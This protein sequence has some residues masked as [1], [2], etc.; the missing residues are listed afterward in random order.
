MTKRQEQIVSGIARKLP[1]KVIADELGI[2]IS[3][4]C[5]HAQ[6]LANDLGVTKT[7]HLPGEIEYRSWK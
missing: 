1:Y 5:S 4:A 7:K 6:R 2:S 3:T